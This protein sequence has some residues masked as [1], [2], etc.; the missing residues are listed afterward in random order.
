MVAVAAT[1]VAVR[2][3]RDAT[4]APP[5]PATNSAATAV[6]RY[7]V[8]LGA[9]SGVP[10]SQRDA[11]VG[12]S[13][14]GKVLATVKPSAGLT[15]AGVSGAADDRTF[16][17]DAASDAE[18]APAHGTHTWYRLRLAPGT[19]RPATVTKLP[20][21]QPGDSDQ[22]DGLALSPDAGTLAILY[23]TGVL[24][25]SF[26]PFILRT[27]SLRTGKPVHNWTA[28]RGKV[29]VDGGGD[30]DNT[31]DLTWTAD[32]TTLAFVFPPFSWPDYERTLR[33]ADQGTSLLGDSHSVLAIP[34][35]QDNC[36]SLLLASDGR[37]MICGTVG[38]GAR[39]CRQQEPQFDQYSTATGKLT[40]VLYRFHGTCQSADAELA[41]MGSGGTAIGVIEALRYGDNRIT[42]DYTVGVLTPGKFTPLHV[43]VPTGYGF[44]TGDLAF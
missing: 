18:A 21:A 6:P 29:N 14:T 23:Q 28:P 30:V 11:I 38:N 39:G 22:I 26:G 9:Y 19:A 1:L 33:V 24:R 16:V 12:D 41:W 20:I 42:T 15:F 43:P 8:Q 4:P 35:N 36:T 10:G 3:S 13:R 27:F 7:Y 2:D 32:G 34:G 44:K 40:R 17:L 37:T 31:V 5:A 25:G